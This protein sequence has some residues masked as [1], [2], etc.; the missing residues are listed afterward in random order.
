M[1]DVVIAPFPPSD[2]RDWECQCARCGSSVERRLCEQCDGMGRTADGE[3]HEEDPLWYDEDD[4]EACH[5]CLGAGGWWHCLSD[6]AWCKDHP[7]EGRENVEPGTVE[8]FVV[9]REPAP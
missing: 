3:L 7:A 8:W 6:E 2:G 1:S 4:F 5:V 9:E